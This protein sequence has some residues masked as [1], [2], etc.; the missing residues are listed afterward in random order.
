MARD[1]NGVPCVTEINIGRFFT[2]VPGVLRKAG[3]NMAAVYADLCVG[4]YS[5]AA[6]RL[7]ARP[8]N[9][10]ADGVK[11]IRAMDREPILVAA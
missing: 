9:P 7:A 6:Q 10:I 3:F 8:L 1:N 5:V 4:H 2:T 11:W